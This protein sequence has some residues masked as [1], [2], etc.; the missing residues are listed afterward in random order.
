MT[1]NLV[2]PTSGWETA[3]DAPLV[4]AAAMMLIDTGDGFVGFDDVGVQVAVLIEDVGF[5]TPDTVGPKEVV[6]PLIDGYV[7]LFAGAIA[8]WR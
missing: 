7:T 2:A 4:V 1:V 5:A 3:G 8:L 6:T